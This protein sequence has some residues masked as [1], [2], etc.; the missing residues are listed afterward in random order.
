[1]KALSLGTAQLGL[2]YGI[3]NRVSKMTESMAVKILDAAWS[4]G[5]RN[6]DTCSAYGD[7]ENRIIRYMKMHP[8]RDFHVTTKTHYTWPKTSFE[9][10]GATL[11]YWSVGDIQRPRGYEVDGVSLYTEQE[12]RDTKFDYN[13]YELPASALDGRND[14]IIRILFAAGKKVQIRSLLIQGLV[15]IDPD[16]CPLIEA[17]PYICALQE[18]AADYSMSV[19]EL[20][21]RW[22]GYLEYPELAIV[23]AERVQQVEQN[24]EYFA[25]GS[26]PPKLIEEVLKLR[27]GIPAKVVSPK[28]WGQTFKFES[29][30]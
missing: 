19:I 16:D 7:C 26:L 15:T 21:I 23:G 27:K 13:I 5:I 30:K 6:L 4:C 1:M 8:D 11:C 28:M 18:L 14:E 22:F 2:Q 12:V 10:P 29:S 25:K 3:A 20:C 9:K 17:R 24:A